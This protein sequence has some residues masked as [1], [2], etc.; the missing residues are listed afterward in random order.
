MINLERIYQLLEERE[1]DAIV[2]KD[3]KCLRYFSDYTGG[4][5]ILIIGYDYR[6]LYTDSRYIES[7]SYE[8]KCFKVRDI[9][10][11]KYSECI[12]DVFREKEVKRAGFE[13][14]TILLKDY[15]Q[16]TQAV[17]NVTW[18]DI[19]LEIEELRMVKNSLE[20]ANIE[21]AEAI[22]DIAFNK[23]LGFIRPGITEREI[24]MELERVMR[25]NG[26][27][28]LSFDTIVASGTN[29]SMPH[30]NVTEREIEYGDF[31][32]MDFGCKYDGYCSDMTRTIVVGKANDEQRKIY[33]TVLDA[34]RVALE[35]IR[36][37]MV[38]SQVDKMARDYISNAGF[39]QYFGH[40]LGHS[41]GLEIHEA[42]TF[43]MK[44][45]RVLSENMIMTVEPGIYLPGFGGVR[46][47]DLVL[48]TKDG[49]RNLTYSRKDLI[50][51]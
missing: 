44:C 9:E 33:Q 11:R 35:V 36:E 5:G 48:I 15:Q 14:N 18:E 6:I 10:R 12:A 32:I 20:I 37:G 49:Y 42:P 45:D 34:Q 40:A 50:E 17:P 1:L 21:R 13:G 38:C 39:G 27:S 43:S 29:S 23:I 19:S 31:V 51:L 28:G 24:A 25:L 2:I 47:E 22:G 3:G 4:E 26:A 8:A 41:V 16:M 7:A 46:I 30:A